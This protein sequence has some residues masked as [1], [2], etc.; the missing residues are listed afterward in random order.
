MI[1]QKHTKVAG[2]ERKAARAPVRTM[3][4][5][6]VVLDGIAPLTVRF[7]MLM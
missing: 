6:S 2:K 7:L 3:N 1:T 4:V 5:P